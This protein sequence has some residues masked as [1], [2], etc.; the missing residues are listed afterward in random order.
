MDENQLMAM[1]EEIGPERLLMILQLFMSM[2][3]QQIQALANQLSQMIQQ[4]A[5][6]APPQEQGP[7]GRENL[8]G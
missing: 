3:D 2:S 6:A 8:Y 4:Q 5:S 1:L 7:A